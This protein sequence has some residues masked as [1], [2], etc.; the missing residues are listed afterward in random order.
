[1]SGR[2]TIIISSL[3]FVVLFNFKLVVA[4]ARELD[5]NQTTHT[6]VTEDNGAVF[7]MTTAKAQGLVT[8]N[9]QMI[10][11]EGYLYKVFAA[12]LTGD[13]HHEIIVSSKK[14]GTGSLLSYRVYDLLNGEL[15]S[16]Y[17]KENI[18]KG[19]MEIN[20]DK[21]VER[22]PVYAEGDCNAL[23]SAYMQNTY[24]FDG[25]TFVLDNSV[26]IVS[27]LH[28]LTIGPG[29]NPSQAEIENMMEEAAARVGIPACILKSI[30]YTESTFQQYKDGYPISPDGE[31]SWG[32]MQVNTT[33]HPEY[34]A[35]RLKYD[36]RYNIQAGAEILK[37]NW[38]RTD[39]SKIGN[40]DP[41]VLE[42]WYFA[43]WAYNG[44]SDVNNPN[45]SSKP[46]VYQ[47][48]VICFAQAQFGQVITKIEA[49]DLPLTGIPLS[50]DRYDTPSPQHL[51]DL[52]IHKGDIL[53]DMT[54]TSG[55]NLRDQAQ[56][57]VT[58]G[59]LSP[60]DGMRVVG[61]EPVGDGEYLRY[62]VKTLDGE[63]EGWV[64]LKWVQKMRNSDVQEDGITDVFDLVKIAKKVG[65]SLTTANSEDQFD[66]NYDGKID[67]ED[68]RLAARKYR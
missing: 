58:V 34:E 17:E 10:S 35:E 40:H 5:L 52:G 9:D 57:G 16:L 20:E 25:T 24:R 28:S 31:S 50:G 59:T 4:T 66:L 22:I 38:H 19:C 42:N 21:I 68:I 60:R 39:I 32:I 11:M 67:R 18:Y 27:Q 3:I 33:W 26:K 7:N 47:D 37:D 23:P 45:C 12:D 44:W 30:A 46:E 8:I 65:C 56:D 43:I 51:I 6:I 14:E 54:T 62:H 64:V 41:Q 63:L 55:V 49:S 48:K 61:E 29:V 2:K 15:N 36:I 53:I 13:G 1:M